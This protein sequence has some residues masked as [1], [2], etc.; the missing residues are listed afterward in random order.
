MTEMIQSTLTISSYNY[1]GFGL[2]AQNQIEKL[3]YFS[4]ILCLQEHFLIDS[5]DKKYSNIDKLKGKF[6]NFHDMYMVPAV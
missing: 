5:S 2:A 1:T 6:G 4:D 3:L